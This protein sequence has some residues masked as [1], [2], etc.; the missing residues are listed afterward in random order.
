MDLSSHIQALSSIPPAQTAAL[1]YHD[2][3]AYLRSPW[4]RYDH[5]VGSEILS[6]VQ[7]PSVLVVS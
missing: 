5:K 2:T 6:K 3:L 4:L 1:R 7:D